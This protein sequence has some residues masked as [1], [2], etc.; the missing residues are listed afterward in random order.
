[1]STTKELKVKIS[2]ETKA[3]RDMEKEAIA[4]SKKINELNKA[5]AN[6][7][8]DTEQLKNELKQAKQAMADLKVQT[9]QTKSN[10]KDYS[11]TT[12]E[13]SEN[14]K[15]MK[16]F[17]TKVGE[18]LQDVGKKMTAIGVGITASIGGI[19]MKG[20]E[21]SAQVEG[22]KFLY[23]NLDK[24]V[25]KS[26]DSNAKNAQAIGLT[27]QQYKNGATDISTYY[28]NMG[29]TAEATADLS[30]KTMDLVADLGAVKDVPFDE[31]L[32]DFKSALM[33]NYEA[34]DKY[35]ISLSASTL[36]NSEFVKSLGKSWNQLSDNEKMMAAYNEIVR[37]GSSA[38][39]LAKKEADSFGMQLKL[40]KE[41]I[42]E[43]VGEIGSAL[44]PTLEPLVQK[45][46]E[47]VDEIVEWVKENPE[48][49]RNILEVTG[50]IGGLLAVAGPLIALIGGITL[51]V[52]AFDVAMLPVA[53][54][55]ALVVGAIVA[56]IAL[57][58]FNWDWVKDK[59]K[60]VG[61]AFK[62]FVKT[63]EENFNKLKEDVSK[64]VQDVIKWFTDMKNKVGEAF[65]N[66]WQTGKDNFTRLKNDL[67]NAIT[68]A[69]D[70]VVNK[71]NEIK[72]G[73]IEKFNSAKSRVTEIFGNIK[74]GIE[75]KINGARDAVSRAID[76]IK[77]FMNFE[78]SLP[79]LK[80]PHISISG[81]FSLSPPS[82]PKFGISW[83]S[84]GAIFK[85]PTVLGGMG[86]GDA[87][88]GIG[89]NAEAILPINQLPKLLGLDKL[90][91]NSG[92]ALN[93]EN[94][95]NNTDKDIEY[96]ANEL[97]FYMRRKN[98]GIGGAY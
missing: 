77:G 90:Q 32:A 84:K 46:S 98:I 59:V 75:D 97:A 96:L 13:A 47:V 58:C 5:I 16:E 21:W 31:A 73:I 4:L 15:K 17:T 78:W 8:G 12:K 23:N 36:E 28:K 69:K 34:V 95:N 92:I 50:V 18:G 68:S 79:K 3:L 20:S 45:F 14:T 48:L 64:V 7:D 67:T 80:L 83:Y 19:V 54:T 72:T 71:A 74:Q 29:L 91:N 76:K 82:V 9:S 30:G 93:I 42:S 44:L 56:G 61:E 43:L 37:Q 11:E 57:L 94:F 49:V 41:K 24:A 52:V 55:V 33:G 35:G 40:L 89:S 1:M 26:I 39:G 22:Q 70:S 66:L 86:V 27:A 10:L 51:A 81:S 53:G 65:T 60:E 63:G 85:R 62:N 25:Q 87:H 6:G 38:K 2:A 88:N